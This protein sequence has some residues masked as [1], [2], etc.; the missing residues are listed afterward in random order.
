MGRVRAHRAEGNGSSYASYG[1]ARGVTPKEGEKRVA[2]KVWEVEEGICIEKVEP[3]APS[4]PEGDE[5]EEYED[6]EEVKH[7]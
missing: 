5:E 3:E 4:N 7:K 6:V 1:P 2:L